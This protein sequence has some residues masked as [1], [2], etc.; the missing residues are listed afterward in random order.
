MRAI[1]AATS[2]TVFSPFDI[3]KYSATNAATMPNI[4]N[5]SGTEY[6]KVCDN[7]ASEA[8]FLNICVWLLKAYSERP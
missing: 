5:I 8:C 1:K 6:V 7:N 2:V 3:E 4:L